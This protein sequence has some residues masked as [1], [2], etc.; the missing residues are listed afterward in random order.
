[1]D[2]L[3]PTKTFLRNVALKLILM[4]AGASCAQ[5]MIESSLAVAD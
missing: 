3:N 2:R 5:Q 4:T 1:M